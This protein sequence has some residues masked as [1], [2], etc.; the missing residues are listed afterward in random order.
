MPAANAQAQEDAESFMK[1]VGKIEVNT[2][3]HCRGCLRVVEQRGGRIGV[4]GVAGA[5]GAVLGR[6]V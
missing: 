5:A 1:R 3:A 4:A 6:S 2:C